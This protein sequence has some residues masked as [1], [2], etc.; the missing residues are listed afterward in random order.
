MNQAQVYDKVYFQD[1]Y[2][3]Q[4]EALRS[5]YHDRTQKAL[6]G[7]A[8]DHTPTSNIAEFYYLHDEP[9][10][11]VSL[12]SGDLVDYFNRRYGGSDRIG[13]MRQALSNAAKKAEK[14]CELA[15]KQRSEKAR[16]GG[17]ALNCRMRFSRGHMVLVN[18]MFAF[19]LIL[20]VVLLGASGVMLERSE[21]DVAATELQLAQSEQVQAVSS[22]DDGGEAEGASAAYLACAN[23]NVTE[24]YQV[25]QKQNGM[26]AFLRALA[27]LW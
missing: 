7:R 21:A 15:K 26:D 19:M 12:T 13:A 3:Q 6:R 2:K 14:S 1:D 10:G 17:M 27:Y 5:R 25:E 24:V 23:E 9:D 22:F 16:Q 4:F 8:V 18:M 20:S 11:G